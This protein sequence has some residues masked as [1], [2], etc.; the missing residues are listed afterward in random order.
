MEEIDL[1]EGHKTRL[2]LNDFVGI[3]ALIESHPSSIDGTPC[4]G[5][6]QIAEGE[7]TVIEREPLTVLPSINCAYCDSHGTI[8]AGKWQDN[9]TEEDIAKWTNVQQN[10]SA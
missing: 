6:V 4:G 3:E 2:L 7:W 8:I 10:T 5:L 9:R 1:G